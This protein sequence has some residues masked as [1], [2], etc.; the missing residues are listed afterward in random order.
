MIPEN[1]K[2]MKDSYLNL[3]EYMR[4]LNC[5]KGGKEPT[6]SILDVGV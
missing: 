3:D 4:F 6:L 2:D 5:Q 1:N